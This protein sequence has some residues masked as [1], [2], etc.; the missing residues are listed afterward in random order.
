[1]LRPGSSIVK[2]W[3]HIF[4][5]LDS[6]N[7]TE[8]LNKY[9]ATDNYPSWYSTWASKL[10]LKLENEEDIIDKSVQSKRSRKSSMQSASKQKKV[11]NQTDDNDSMVRLG[12]AT[13][14]LDDAIGT[15]NIPGTTSNT[16]VK[17]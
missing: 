15:A 11:E 14:E 12:E 4:L 2:K 17:Y 10:K 6:V 3:T 16:Q 9:V 8:S 1:M 13:I 5:S 7:L